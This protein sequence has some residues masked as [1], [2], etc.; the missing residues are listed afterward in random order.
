MSTKRPWV[1]LI[2]L[3]YIVGFIFG[4]LGLGLISKGTLF[5]NVK[6]AVGAKGS[7]SGRQI[8]ETLSKSALPKG[9]PARSSKVVLFTYDVK[10]GSEAQLLIKTLPDMVC[11]IRY[12]NPR[13][14][15]VPLAMPQYQMAGPDGL[16]GWAWEIPL[17]AE[18]GVGM[19][20]FAAGGTTNTL[21]FNI[22][23]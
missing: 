8:V 14:V 10:V 15:D 12:V 3:A 7:A 11:T 2:G 4:C 18:Q 1:I 16:C 19:V 9:M 5:E 20:I 13:G 22:K 21:F 23:H 17:E 6:A